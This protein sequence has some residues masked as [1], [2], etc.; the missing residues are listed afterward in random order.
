MTLVRGFDISL[1]VRKFGCRL[2]SSQ[3]GNVVDLAFDILSRFP[4][5]DGSQSFQPEL[6]AIAE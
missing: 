3:R 5:I 6:L 1:F 2:G 4:E